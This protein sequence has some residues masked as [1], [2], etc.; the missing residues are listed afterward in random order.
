MGNDSG[1]TRRRLL[2]ISGL[3]AVTG[4]LAGCLDESTTDDDPGDSTDDDDGDEP[5]TG[6]ETDVD[7]GSGADGSDGDAASNGDNT[8]DTDDTDSK[9][10]EG[11]PTETDR[12]YEIEPGTTVVFRSLAMSWEGV[13]PSPIEGAENPNLILQEGESYTITWAENEQGMHNLA[14]YDDSESAVAGPTELV[15]EDEPD[16]S[17]EFEA[18]S[19]TVEY[20][21]EPHY[22]VGMKGNIELE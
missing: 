22:D 14:I 5:G 18:S 13:A 4:V 7:D 6:G 3:T 20:V 11:E 9:D 12:G 16:L 10:G 15:S 2:R 1:P 17:V 19:D 21:C 8:V